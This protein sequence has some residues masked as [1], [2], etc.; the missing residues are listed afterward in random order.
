[1]KLGQR[2]TSLGV[3]KRLSIWLR[4]IATG[5]ERGFTAIRRMLLLSI[6]LSIPLTSPVHAQTTRV[7]G[8]VRDASGSSVPGAQ[9]ALR[10]KTY[11]VTVS[12]NTLGGF[13][14][15]MFPQLLGLSS[16]RR[17]DF[18]RCRRGGALSL[19]RGQ[20]KRTMHKPEV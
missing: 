8:A 16:L 18:N 3:P 12:T 20:Q 14:S 10:A 5:G 9:A 11:S 13:P 1:M 19:G 6:L 7:E 4:T 17:R 2:G 15:K